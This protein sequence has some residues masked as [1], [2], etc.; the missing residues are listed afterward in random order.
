MSAS[1]V[2][3]FI[4]YPRAC[5]LVLICTAVLLLW[6][7]FPA[8]QAV[9]GADWYNATGS[10][11]FPARYGHSSVAFDNGSGEKIWVIGGD[12]GTSTYLD[13]VW[14]SA[15]GTTW[16]KTGTLPAP[17]F[18]HSSVVFG[19]KVWVMGGY[20]DTFAAVNEVW[21]SSDGI[22]WNEATPAADF[23][24]RKSHS[25]RGLR[26]QDMGDRRGRRNGDGIR[27]CLEF[28]RRD[29]LEPGNSLGRV[30]RAGRS[31]LCCLQ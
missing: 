15:D 2:P 20:D 9:T 6:G 5:T 7:S 10:S 25:S 13:D 18:G 19:S 21:N 1:R 8:V 30:P 23:A 17:R 29:H 14:S 28:H 26:Q 22:T 24:K 27:R 16:G 3:V 31:L 4:L 11:T 12:D